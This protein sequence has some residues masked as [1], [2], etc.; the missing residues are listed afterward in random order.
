MSMR[1]A[2]RSVLHA[3]VDIS[4]APLQGLA[5]LV[6]DLDVEPSAVFTR[7]GIDERILTDPANRLPFDV[8]GRL[9][10]ECAA[11]CAR[12]DFGLLLGIRS[13]PAATG[14]AGHLFL[15][16]ET[17]REALR[18][19]ITHLHLHD[20]GGVATLSLRGGADAE[21]SYVIHHANTPGTPQILDASVAI[22]CSI[23]RSLCGPHWRPSR[24]TLSHGRPRIAGRYRRFF[25]APV[26]FDAPRSALVFPA[27]H[28]DRPIAGADPA[29]RSHLL[30]LAAEL[31]AA[32]P[33]SVTE[34]T[35]RTLTHMVVATPP[36]SA[37]V[38]EAL[39][40]KPRRL[41]ERLAAEG[42][43]V[44]ELLEDLRCELA[45]QL[46]E[47]SRMP[48]GEVAATLH[49][50]KPG[51]FSRAF[52]GWTGKTPRQWRKTVAVAGHGP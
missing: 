49:Y 3:A 6:R 7:A 39:G 52:K 38:A 34:L 50:S 45:R 51:A 10:D 18:L 33:A 25:R 26:T 9:L 41:R 4:V 12:P 35:L 28:L 47:E 42:S 40:M 22:A 13:G 32:R 29:T 2:Q 46:L 23:M 21:L 14:V 30:E 37:K 27:S 11:S 16:A 8:A 48:I 36:S 43:S 24:V 15:H 44:K 31:D 20:R 1:A 5:D 17:V 19:F